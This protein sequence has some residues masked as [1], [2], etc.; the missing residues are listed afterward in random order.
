[1]IYNNQGK[2]ACRLESKLTLDTSLKQVVLIRP[3]KFVK[4]LSLPKCSV[5]A[6]MIKFV[7]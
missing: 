2:I 3:H 4:Q 5:K 7:V 6:K 1:M